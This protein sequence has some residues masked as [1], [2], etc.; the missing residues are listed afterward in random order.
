[1]RADLRRRLLAVARGEF[2]RKEGVTPVSGV[3]GHSGYVS[4][5]LELRQVRALRVKNHQLEKEVAKG[6]TE[7]VTHPLELDD[8]V[9]ERFAIIE[10][11]GTVPAMFREAWARLNCACPAGILEDRWN[12]G[13][14]R[15]F[16]HCKRQAI[17]R[18]HTDERRATDLHILDGA[19]RLRHGG[20]RN[21]FEFMRQPRL[22]DDLD[23][24][25][26]VVQPNGSKNPASD[27][28]ES[29]PSPCLYSIADAGIVMSGWRPLIKGYFAAAR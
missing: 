24:R 26:F 19:C 12:V 22:I 29:A 16:A 13:V 7:P 23:A 15:L 14:G 17:G 27:P 2:S 20:D 1:M 10:E 4:K 28:H 11:D 8:A 18:S 25:P 3:T 21:D 9:P 6:V 5:P